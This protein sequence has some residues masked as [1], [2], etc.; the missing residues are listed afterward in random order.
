MVRAIRSSHAIAG[1][2]PAV[3]LIHGVGA[4]R[5]AWDGVIE[6][7]APH[8]RCISYDLRGHGNSEGAD[9]PFGL[10]EFVADL[11][12]LRAEL[13][14]EQAHFVGHSLGGMIA[15]AYAR[16]HPGRARSLALISTVAFR[17]PE[18][19][20]NL[21][22]FVKKMEEGGTASVID[23]LM[24]R[25]FTDE[26]RQANPEVVGTRRKLVLALDPRVYRE[27]YTVYATTDTGPWLPDFDMPA[28]VMTGENDPGCPP[29]LNKRMAE[30][31]P[32]GELVILPRLRHSILAEGPQETAERLLSFLLAAE[33]KAAMRPS[34]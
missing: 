11:E 2:G 24:D 10:A 9:Q 17:G 29:A 32:Q 4:R 3:F 27:T 25:W 14:I 19:R 12:A 34:A 33:H 1:K 15:P 23:T 7:L 21:D 16:A 20:I 31:L 28:L 8:F 6:R 18:A 22:A 26:F 5:Q 13:G 30:A